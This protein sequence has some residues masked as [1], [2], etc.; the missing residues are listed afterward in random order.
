MSL[1]SK[2]SKPN[3]KSKQSLLNK[4]DNRL[5]SDP[6]E[7]QLSWI[8][9]TVEPEVNQREQKKPKKEDK[10]KRI[11]RELTK[12]SQ[13]GL[14]ENW[15]RA[16]FIVRED[17]LDKLKDYAYTERQQ[18]KDIVNDILEGFLRDKSTIQR[19]K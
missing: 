18:I 9:P 12:S 15:T 13:E 4:Q 1:Q 11:K 16:T 7:N 2:Q 19:P 3:N 17:I 8:Q 6:F 10:V 14:P 5:G